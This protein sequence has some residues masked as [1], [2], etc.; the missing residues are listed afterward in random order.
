MRHSSFDPDV[1]GQAWTEETVFAPRVRAAPRSPEDGSHHH[2]CVAHF[3]TEC[4]KRAVIQ[5]RESAILTRGKRGTG[6]CNGESVR[7]GS[8]SRFHAR[9]V[10]SDMHAAARLVRR[11]RDQGRARRRR[12][13]HARPAARHPG[14][15]QPL[16]H[17]AEPQ[18]ALDHRR[19]QAS[20]GQEGARRRSSSNATCSSRT[21]RR[22]RSTGWAS[23]GSASRSSIPR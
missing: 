2:R 17:D 21:S 18:Q 20:E 8:D 6:E 13:H 15:R 12:R 9:A 3:P 23:R 14:R 5:V 7:R 11:R 4:S 19:H 22:A 10:G 1:N 16:L